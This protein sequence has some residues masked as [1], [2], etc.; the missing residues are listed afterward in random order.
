MLG[1]QDKYECF[2]FIADWHALT[3]NYADTDKLLQYVDEMVLDWLAIGLDPNKCAIYRQSDM[4]EIAELALYFSMLTP[5]AWL[6]RN[7]TY[8]EQLNELKA[9]EIATHGFIGYPVLQA[10][11]IL[12]VHADFVPVG[13][14]QLPHLELS[15]EIAR[16]F[17]HFYGK[18]LKEPKALLSHTKRLPGIDGRKMSKSYGNAIYLNDEPET[19]AK[20]VMKMITDPEKIRKNDPGHPEICSVFALHKLYSP[21]QAEDIAARCR[22]GELGCVADKGDL[23]EKICS[24]LKPYQKRRLELARDPDTVKKV[25]AGG[26]AKAHPLISETLH[27]VRRLIK[28]ERDRK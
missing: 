16:R 12:S 10:A 26:A 3:T 24:S 11:D 17:N 18:Y 13:E 4:M 1:L 21:E 27:Q 25:L 22:S 14:D 28:I 23:A 19:I 15:R 7:P 20:K 6:E 9:K 8:K 2:F 5:I